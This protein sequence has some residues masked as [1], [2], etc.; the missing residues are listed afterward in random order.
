MTNQDGS[1]SIRSVSITNG[2]VGIVY[3]PNNNA[4]A[5]LPY[6][7]S[8]NF[9]AAGF[10]G[11]DYPN[12]DTWGNSNASYIANYKRVVT[13]QYGG[14]TYSQRS[15]TKYI[16]CNSRVLVG[17]NNTSSVVDVFGGDTYVVAYDNVDQFPDFNQ[18]AKLTRYFIFACETSINTE[19]RGT[20]IGQNVPNKNNPPG[21]VSGQGTLD[22]SEVYDKFDNNL[23]SFDA[24]TKVYFPK[25]F[26]FTEQTEFDTRTFRSDIKTNGELIDSWSVFNPSSFLDVESKYGP[27]NNLIVFQDKL[28]FFQDR[29][30][31]VFQIN[32][33]VALT[34]TN[35][36]EIILGSSG[37]LER[38]DYVSTITGSKHQFSF[39]LSDYSVI[40]LDILSRKLYRF[41]PGKLEPVTDV[42]GYRA[43]L[44]Q[45]LDGNIQNTDNPYI[46]TGVHATYDA[47]YNEY[48][49]TFI[50]R[51]D[52]F[53]LTLVYNE[54]VDGFIGRYT[55]YPTVYI[56]DKLN[57][58]GVPYN[59]GSDK[60]TLHN[61]GDYGRFIN[62]IGAYYTYGST[63]SYVVNE[64]PTIEKVLTNQ[65]YSV[66]V[67]KTNTDAVRYNA[68]AEI[69]ISK[70][71]DQFRYFNT[72]QNTDWQDASN[73]TRRHK[74]MWN[75]KV[76][77]DRVLDVNQNIFTTSNLA[78][79]RP[80]FTRRLKDKWFMCEASYL[81][82]DNYK[83]IVNNV[84]S[85]YSLNSI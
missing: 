43:L 71:F 55:S 72:Y 21:N 13:N 10:G 67:Y 19:L 46:G 61:Y 76:P 26:G 65:R 48:R 41:Y 78:N 58:F 82:T 4:V 80:K 14:N 70:T 24:Y 56:N 52:A 37:I 27:I 36:S 44:Y 39:A 5:G 42:K 17:P 79:P 59:L 3:G 11:H 84:T 68:F 49:I 31:G 6:G 12:L 16:N 29:G 15:F 69:D 62:E 33:K 30:F 83:I 51:D 60:I 25:P 22:A 85:I 2:C 35:D 47:R 54:M 66:D 57:I 7:G 75:V 8:Y 34:D 81:N 23:L 50:H 18:T 77:T 45:S 1:T 9:L 38:F 40:W 64:N 74:T 20:G 32:E 73:L 28:Y 63:I 53:H